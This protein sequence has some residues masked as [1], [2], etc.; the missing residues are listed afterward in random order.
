MKVILLKE[1]KH[2]GKRG[3]I[4]EVA[5]G[6]ARNF[7][8]PQKMALL[9]SDLNLKEIANEKARMAANSSKRSKELKEIIKKLDGL[10]LETALKSTPQGHLFGSVNEDKIIKLLSE[11]GLDISR[12]EIILPKPIK[13]LGS[14]K[15][16]VDMGEGIGSTEITL[17]VKPV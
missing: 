2:I 13:S 1:I 3:D 4:K 8:L 10:R 17:E 12:K 16:T 11:K 5:D 7:L 9:A 14:H 15:V 6:Y